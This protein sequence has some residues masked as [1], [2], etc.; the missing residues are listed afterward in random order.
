MAE[1]LG[2]ALAQGRGGQALD[3]EILSAGVAAV[4]GEPASANAVQALLEGGIDL[5]GHLARQLNHAL[6]NDVDLVLT[7]TRRHKD[8]ILQ[9]V[10]EA[11]GKVFVLWEYAHGLERDISDPFGQ[12]LE[13][14]RQCAGE[15][16]ECIGKIL[17]K[18][19]SSTGK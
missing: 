14:Y 1:A 3:I 7:M 8:I 6:I 12:P 16:K 11:A 17:D 19:A 4:P 18:L 13:V 9:F 2:R 15:L 5:S 10:P